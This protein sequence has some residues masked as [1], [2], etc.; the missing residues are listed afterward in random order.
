MSALLNSKQKPPNLNLVSP[1][2]AAAQSITLVDS[3]GHDLIGYKVNDYGR[4]AVK[5]SDGIVRILSAQ[6]VAE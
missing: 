2:P 6:D 5:K 4:V 1:K 3:L